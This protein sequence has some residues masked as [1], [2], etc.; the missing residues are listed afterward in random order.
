MKT[1]STIL[2][3]FDFSEVALNAL[4][5]AIHFIENDDQAKIIL[6]HVEEGEITE[7]NKEKLDQVVQ[8]FGTSL[9]HPIIPVV[10]KGKMIDALLHI[11]DETPI[12]LVVMGTCPD[13]NTC[14]LQTKTSEFVLIAKCPVIVIPNGYTQTSVKKIALIIDKEKIHNNKLLG[15]LLDVSRRFNAIVNVLTVVNS[16]EHYGYTENDEKNENDIIYYLE[17]FY[18]HHAFIEDTDIVHGLF[19][20]VEDNDIDLVAILPKNHAQTPVTSEGKLTKAL[21]QQTKVPLLAIDL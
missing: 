14:N 3:P 16:D 2:V 12:D 5:Y 4:K 10:V 15:V 17:N 18:S 7:E 1:I 20:Y 13:Y 11:Q 6:A 19:N 8:A 9:R 21:S